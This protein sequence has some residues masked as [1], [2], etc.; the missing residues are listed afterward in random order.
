MTAFRLLS[1]TEQRIC[2]TLRASGVAW[3]IESLAEVIN[4]PTSEVR[5][6]CER[7]ADEGRISRI[8]KM[9]YTTQTEEK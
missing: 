2:G 8:G 3:A 6:A 1:D 5:A 4:A 9:Y 7:L